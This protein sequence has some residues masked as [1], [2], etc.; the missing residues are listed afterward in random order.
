MCA[1]VDQM[2]CTARLLSLNNDGV[3]LRFSASR[4]VPSFLSTIHL[5]SFVH[6]PT[7]VFSVWNVNFYGCPTYMTVDVH[8]D[9]VHLRVRVRLVLIP[10]PP[11]GPCLS[12]ARTL[13]LAV[14]SL[15]SRGPLHLGQAQSSY[16]PAS[17]YVSLSSLREVTHGSRSR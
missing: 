7:Y 17:A 1:R 10:N 11:V 8:N 12:R 6:L 16:W 15:V 14:V 13:P 2:Y 9:M 5:L 4:N 3:F